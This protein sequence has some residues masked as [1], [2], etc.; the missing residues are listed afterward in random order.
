MI[1]IGAGVGRR[2]FIWGRSDAFL[3]SIASQVSAFQNV[4]GN[5]V[6]RISQSAP[7]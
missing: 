6:V 7:L 3:K 2:F 4:G 1:F 5:V